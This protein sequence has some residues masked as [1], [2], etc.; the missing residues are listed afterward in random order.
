MANS[1][2]AN[3]AY[4][5]A[6][7][8]IGEEADKELRWLANLHGVGFIRLDKEDS[9]NSSIVIPAKERKEVDW[10]MFYRLVDSNKK[11]E[12]DYLKLA[13]EVLESKRRKKLDINEWGIKK[14]EVDEG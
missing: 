6:T 12:E 7:K 14:I 9:S 3:F 5:V 8:I 2:W 1:C 13:N 4:L 11:Y 10:N